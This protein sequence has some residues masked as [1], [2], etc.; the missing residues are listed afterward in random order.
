[1]SNMTYTSDT[2]ENLKM[3]D[4][5]V[6]AFTPTLTVISMRENGRTT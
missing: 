1:M 3:D 2:M 5:M 6:S 4:T